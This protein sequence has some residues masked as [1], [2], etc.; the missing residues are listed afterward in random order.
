MR[1]NEAEDRVGGKGAEDKGG[2]MK[3]DG[4]GVKLC[5][6]SQHFPQAVV[7]HA[8]VMAELVCNKRDLLVYS[9]NMWAHC[10]LVLQG[11]AC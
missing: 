5:V 9:Q 2:R 8:P 3:G 10:E 6:N 11:P 1:R 7:P 4:E